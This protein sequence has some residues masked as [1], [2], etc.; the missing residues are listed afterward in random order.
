MEADRTCLRPVAIARITVCCARY[1]MAWDVPNNHATTDVAAI[2]AALK[3]TPDAGTEPTGA[4]I[5]VMENVGVSQSCMVASVTAADNTAQETDQT[6]DV[7]AAFLSKLDTVA[8]SEPEFT[9]PD[10]AAAA[11]AAAAAA[12]NDG[13]VAYGCVSI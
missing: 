8:A 10:E 11:A 7:H 5:L 9:P 12:Q 6:V 13:G 2:V 4:R 1:N 3:S